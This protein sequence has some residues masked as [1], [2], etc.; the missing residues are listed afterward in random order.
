MCLSGLESKCRDNNRPRPL[1]PTCILIFM[2]N[3]LLRYPQHSKSPNNQKHG[4]T[5]RSSPGFITRM[6]P[7]ATFVNYVF[8]IK[9]MRSFRRLDIP[10]I[11][12][13][14]RA[15]SEPAD[16]NG[17]GCLDIRR[18]KGHDLK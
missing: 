1:P 16:N 8:I 14:S 9:V 13:F 10:F 17:C 6:W 4:D 3:P 7:V 11:V 12:T 5:T 15:A 18:L 2:H